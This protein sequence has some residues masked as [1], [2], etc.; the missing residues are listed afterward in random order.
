M[1]TL[2]VAISSL[3]LLITAFLLFKAGLF[4]RSIQDLKVLYFTEITDQNG[5]VKKQKKIQIKAQ[6]LIGEVPVGHAFVIS[7]QISESVDQE[8]LKLIVEEVARPLARIGIAVISKG[9][10][11]L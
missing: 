1:L 8:K 7:E 3:N 2:L 6:L 11:G 10:I 9:T 5:F 4:R